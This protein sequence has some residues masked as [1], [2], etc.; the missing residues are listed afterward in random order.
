MRYQFDNGF[1]RYKNRIVLRS[2]S[3]W[4]EKVFEEHHCKPNASHASF[5]KTY[6]RISRSFYWEGMK[7]NIKDMVVRCDI[8]QKN[9]YETLASAG[10]LNPLHIPQRV[11]FNI[12]MD[13]ITALPH[14]KGKSVIF[15]I[16]DRF[17]K[18]AHFLSLSHLYTTHSVAQLFTDQ[19]FKLRG[20]PTSIVSDKDP[21]FISSFW[22]EFFKL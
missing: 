8:C 20:M 4:R 6:K 5:L 16:I 13:F 21:I 12:S 18:A 22:K 3:S 9:K 2:T 11:W 14:C 17:S 15:A 19:L 10:L 1:L 7:N